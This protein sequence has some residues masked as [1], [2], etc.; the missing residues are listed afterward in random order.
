MDT[1]RFDDLAR[2]LGGRASRRTALGAALA[3]LALPHTGHASV[4][5]APRDATPQTDEDPVFLF[6][7]TA[8]SGRG[9]VNPAAGTPTADGTPT[10]G[11]GAPMLLTLEGHS[12]QTIYFSDR[13]DRIVGAAPTQDF[14]DGLGFTPANP[15]NAALVAEFKAGDGVIVLELIAPVYDEATG[16]LTYGVEELATYAGDNLAPVMREQLV[17]RLPAEFGPSALFIDDCGAYANCYYTSYTWE[18]RYEYHLCGPIPG[19]PYKECWNLFEW[20][21]VP[22]KHAWTYDELVATCQSAYTYECRYPG[23]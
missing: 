7:Q 12:G 19:G 4:Q 21:C 3:G 22:C 16:T 5:D 18:Q 10:P 17:E 23:A 2:R 13:P 1:T 20:G 14:L 15:P 9:E 6:V 11:G 8:A